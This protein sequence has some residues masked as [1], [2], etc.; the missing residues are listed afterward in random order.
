MRE[1]DGVS[2]IIYDQVC[3]TEKRR[4]RKRGKMPKAKVS[5]AINAA[6]CENCGDCTAQSHC[7]AIEPV[8]T[9]HGRK[10]RIS[11]TTCNTDLSC[12]KGFCPSFVTTAGRRR[13]RRAR[14]TAR[15]RRRRRS[16]LA[17][18]PEPPIAVLDHPWRG[19]FAGI[20]GGGIVTCGAI[21]AMAAHLEGS[22]VSTLDFTGLAQKNGAVVSARA[23]RARADRRRAHP[24]GRGRPAAGRRSRGRRLGRRAGALRGRARPWSAISTCR[25]TSPS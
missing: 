11:P 3:A 23:D 4:R 20:G 18:L 1:H 8:E 12:L 25:P 17:G 13:R 9:E 2:A 10:R 21:L 19:L 14:L 15:G 24:G 5:V 7:I 16:L 22:E 6:V